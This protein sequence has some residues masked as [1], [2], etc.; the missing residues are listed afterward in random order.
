MLAAKPEKTTVFTVDPPMHCASCE[1]RIK[2]NLRFERG[3]KAITTSVPD[4]TVTVRYDST[5][6]DTTR[7]IEGFA[8]IGYDAVTVK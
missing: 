5:K 7:I 6:T 1:N 4:Q 3:V 2:S 8:K